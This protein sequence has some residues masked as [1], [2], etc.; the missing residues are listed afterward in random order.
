MP[1]QTDIPIILYFDDVI[2][3]TGSFRQASIV[4]FISS[5]RSVLIC[6]VF[7]PYTHTYN[8][9]FFAAV[10]DI[11]TVLTD[12]SH[13][14]QKTTLSTHMRRCVGCNR[15]HVAMSPP[16]GTAPAFA[17]VRL[18]LNVTVFVGFA[19]VIWQPRATWCGSEENAGHGS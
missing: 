3:S 19:V 10:A 8:L 4:L 5:W 15:R 1:G 14:R 16:Q 7:A 18:L 17:L 11:C 13:Q 9:T 2:W 6:L 12:Q